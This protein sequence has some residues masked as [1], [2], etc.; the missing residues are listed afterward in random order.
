MKLAIT[1]ITV[2]AVA[3]CA[4]VPAHRTGM[5]GN[6]PRTSGDTVVLCHKGKK[7]MQLPRSAMQGHLGHG[8]RLGRC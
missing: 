5:A 8:D 4:V 2:L 6:A 1:A 7:T 3:G